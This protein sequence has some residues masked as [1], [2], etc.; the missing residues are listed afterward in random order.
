MFAFSTIRHTYQILLFTRSPGLLPISASIRL[1]MGYCH[2]QMCVVRRPYRQLR[3]PVFWFSIQFSK[4]TFVTSYDW[5]ND[6]S[7][8]SPFF[9][10]SSFKHILIPTS[11]V[12]CF[13]KDVLRLPLPD[14]PSINDVYKGCPL[15]G[16]QFT[17][18]CSISEYWFLGIYSTKKCY[19]FFTFFVYF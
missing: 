13:V 19:Y 7:R 8:L 5:L 12:T 17:L 2:Q 1:T 6:D 18:F 15:L 9:T 4:N 10:H 11:S 3:T 14:F 16:I